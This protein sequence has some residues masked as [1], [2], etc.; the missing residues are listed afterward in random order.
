[1]VCEWHYNGKTR[2]IDK[3]NKNYSKLNQNYRRVFLLTTIPTTCAQI[4]IP[5]ALKE[6]YY[7]QLKQHK[8]T[9]LRSQTT[10]LALEE[11]MQKV[12]RYINPNK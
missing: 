7:Q 1:M 12:N 6:Y 3:I 10:Q 2:I 8:P 11:E 9:T 4:N 5:W